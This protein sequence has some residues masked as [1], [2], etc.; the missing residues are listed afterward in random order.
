M[1]KN[2][3]KQ[4]AFVFWYISILPQVQLQ[5]ETREIRNALDMRHGEELKEKE[6]FKISASRLP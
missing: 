2:I 6:M 1:D 3:L 4:V 5:M